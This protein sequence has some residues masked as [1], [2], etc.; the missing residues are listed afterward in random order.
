MDIRPFRVKGG[1]WKMVVRQGVIPVLWRGDLK[2]LIHTAASPKFPCLSKY[3]QP[4]ETPS[5]SL[6]LSL[7]YSV[8]QIV[9][10]VYNVPRG[11]SEDRYLEDTC[12]S[13][14]VDR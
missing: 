12:Y 11:T 5:L 14:A 6:S 10:K 13:V 2:V 7:H 3:Y 8:E 9:V 1:G 4:L